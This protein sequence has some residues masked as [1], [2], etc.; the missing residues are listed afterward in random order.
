MRDIVAVAFKNLVPGNSDITRGAGIILHLILNLYTDII[1]ALDVN[2]VL[3]GMITKDGKIAVFVCRIRIVGIAEIA[4]VDDILY[5]RTQIR[6]LRTIL[7]PLHLDASS[8]NHIGRQIIGICKVP[9]AF[10]L[11]VDILPIVVCRIGLGRRAVLQHIEGKTVNRDLGFRASPR[12]TARFL[13]LEIHFL[14]REEM[15]G[16]GGFKLPV[17][18]FRKSMTCTRSGVLVAVGGTICLPRLIPLFVSSISV[19]STEF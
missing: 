8:D 13:L 18:A 19:P 6:R 3:V 4:Q 16:I 2:V 1:H 10:F 12:I 14:Q 7:V 9:S 17:I 15:I 11:P 5:I